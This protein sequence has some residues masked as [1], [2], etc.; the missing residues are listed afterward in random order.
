MWLAAHASQVTGRDI[1]E[2]DPAGVV[3]QR[4]RRSVRGKHSCPDSM[5]RA[6][7][8]VAQVTASAS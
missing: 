7:E 8:L 5:A 6:A 1:I 3:A 2:R 4:K